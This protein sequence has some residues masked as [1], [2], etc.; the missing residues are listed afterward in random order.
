MTDNDRKSAE[1][2][3]HLARITILTP[4]GFTPESYELIKANNRWWCPDCK[5][6][7]IEDYP[8]TCPQCKQTRMDRWKSETWVAQQIALG[9]LVRHRDNIEDPV[10]TAKRIAEMRDE[11]ARVQRERKEARE[12]Y[13]A[14]FEE[15]KGST[16]KMLADAGIALPE[17]ERVFDLIH[18]WHDRPKQLQRFF[19]HYRYWEPRVGYR[20][21]AKQSRFELGRDLIKM[22]D[23][24]MTFRAIG[25]SVDLSVE[26]VRQ[27]YERERRRRKHPRAWD[28]Y[29][30]PEGQDEPT[31]EGLKPPI[32][33]IEEWMAEV[34]WMQGF[35]KK[36]T[37]KQLR[38]YVSYDEDYYCGA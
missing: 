33:P 24:G 1:M 31:K 21:A 8:P 18:F 35:V 29:E 19:K 26:R 14:W 22:R 25:E 7:W 3:A 15:F 10:D 36:V 11:T 20:L 27:I 17:D 13:L 9:K 5:I 2:L 38:Y 12:S 32:S 34:G 28:K 30:W 6:D 23:A 16:I 4:D 37:K